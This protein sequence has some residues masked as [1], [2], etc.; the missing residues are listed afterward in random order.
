MATIHLNLSQLKSIVRIGIIV[1]LIGVFV[2][3]GIYVWRLKKSET[4]LNLKVTKLMNSNLDL[5]SKL[6][7]T[8]IDLNRVVNEDQFVKNRNLQT[9]IDNIHI[10]Y[11]SAMDEYENMLK[12]REF[13]GSTPK[14]EELFAQTLDLLSNQNY[15]SAAAQIAQIKLEIN[16]QKALILAL[17]PTPVPIAINNTAPSSGFSHQLVS[18]DVGQN[19]VD[20]IAADLGST[21]VVVDSA[22]DSDCKNDCPVMALG[23]YVSRNGGYAGV[24]GS[25]FCPSTYPSCVD[26]KNSFDTLLM[27]KNKKYLNSDNNVYSVVPAVIFLGSSVRFVSR[28]L[29]WGRDTGVDG[30]LANQPLVLLGGNIVFN[31]NGDPKIDTRGNR[32]FVGNKGNTVYIGVVYNASVSD[33]GHVLKTLGLDN[34]L[35]LD[36][37]GSTALWF[38]GYK[39]GPGRG[40]PNAIVFVKR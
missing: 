30:V 9:E 21:R 38:G 25:Y 24:N 27:N 36:S 11:K 14:T 4:Q 10:T 37:G 20:L 23:D 3:I 7:Q 17:T 8:Q 40:I 26:K 29:D 1:L 34:A 35:N 6:S 39:I 2:L 16:N 32:S 12:S 28:S 33:V 5:L 18:S 31:G 13:I 22:S 15:A 19:V